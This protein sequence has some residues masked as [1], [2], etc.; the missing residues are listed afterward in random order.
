MTFDKASDR[1]AHHTGKKVPY[2]EKG[3][4][5]H[6]EYTRRRAFKKRLMEKV[7]DLPF[8]EMER[9]VAHEMAQFE[10]R[11]KDRREG[12]VKVRR[13]SKEEK[14]AIAKTTRESGSRTIVKSGFSE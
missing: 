6:R 4:D 14:K 10:L 13:Y 5:S 11:G 9:V 3:T 8:D 7:K 2:I 12:M 1:D